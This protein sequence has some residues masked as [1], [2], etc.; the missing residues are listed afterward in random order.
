MT[1]AGFGQSTDLACVTLAGDCFH[2]TI[3]TMPRASKHHLLKHQD[4]QDSEN[5]HIQDNDAHISSGLV[6]PLYLSVRAVKDQ[7]IVKSGKHVG[8]AQPLAR[9]PKRKVLSASMRLY[10]VTLY[11]YMRYYQI[12]K[13][14]AGKT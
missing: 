8:A 4:T 9:P 7:D 12:V 6:A 13:C 14:E 5:T 3:H 10:A 1:K 11:N 2:C